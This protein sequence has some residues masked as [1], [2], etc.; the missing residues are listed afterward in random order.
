LGERF[1]PSIQ[2]PQTHYLLKISCDN[3]LYK[4]NPK[5][6]VKEAVPVVSKE[7]LV[8]IAET[9]IDHLITAYSSE[10]HL[11]YAEND[12]HAFLYQD[13]L[14][15][16]PIKNW[17]CRTLDGKLSILL[18]EEYPT[19]QRY[20]EKHLKE[21][22]PRGKRG[23]FDLCIWN[24]ENTSGRRFRVTQ[25]TKFEEE[26][27]T[28]VAIEFDLLEHNDSLDQAVHHLKW[29]L[30]KLKSVKNEVEYGFSLV[31][32]RHWVHN[33]EFLKKIK[34]QIER[35]NKITVL[36]AEKTRDQRAA[37]GTMS[38]KR[39]LNYQPMFE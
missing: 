16:L 8:Q 6:I 29:D 38:K 18:H 22:V 24:P 30:M 4:K 3:T 11:F 21:N 27:Q 17:K 33:D 19:K 31:F 34:T 1:Y 9:S 36:Y 12:L 25:S 32:V 13:I 28:F 7:Q 14:N 10:P 37:I 2:F 26:Q 39:F 15:R 20:S 35:E 23:H 5:I